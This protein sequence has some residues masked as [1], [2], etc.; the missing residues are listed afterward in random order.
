MPVFMNTKRTTIMA[1]PK[2][3]RKKKLIDLDRPTII[4]SR[5]LYR[6]AGLGLIFAVILVQ[7]YNFKDPVIQIDP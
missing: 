1:R 6:Q 5:H 7:T 2:S 4:I 3:H